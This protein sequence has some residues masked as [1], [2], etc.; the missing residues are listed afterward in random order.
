MTNSLHRT[1][2]AHQARIAAA[3]DGLDARQRIEADLKTAKDD[4]KP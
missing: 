4:V 2:L 3:A 1:A